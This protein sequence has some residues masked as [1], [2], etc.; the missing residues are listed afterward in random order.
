[1]SPEKFGAFAEAGGLP[2]SFTH[3]LFRW[4]IAFASFGDHMTQ[5]RW[6]KLA[7]YNTGFEVD[8]LCVALDA[9][10]I[11]YL[12]RSL[13]G[14]MDGAGYQG[15]VVGGIDVLVPEDLLEEAQSVLANHLEPN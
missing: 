9:E 14:G 10:A 8:L 4:C 15:L 13:N 2:A 3:E 12:I 7:T 1:M 11:P 6:T 5:S